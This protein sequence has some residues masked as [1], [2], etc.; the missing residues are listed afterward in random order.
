MSDSD[1]SMATYSERS[2]SLPGDGLSVDIRN[3]SVGGLMEDS[4]DDDDD[5]DV[6]DDNVFTSDDAASCTDN[7]YIRLSG[8]PFE[9][10]QPR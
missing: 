2:S 3:T 8:V 6:M 4:G 10:L 7:T 5:D 9:L 1:V